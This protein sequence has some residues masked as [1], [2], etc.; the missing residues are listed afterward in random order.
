ML[1]LGINDGDLVEIISERSSIKCKSYSA[2]DVKVG[3]LA[4]PHGWGTN[5][6]E[7]DDPI[8]SGGN[9]GRLSF[10]DKNFDPIT[11]IPI[12]SAIPVKL[13]KLN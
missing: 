6:D 7:E 5:P 3:C 13:S 11:G 9:T 10:N 4:V 12:M 1:K 8:N 2:A